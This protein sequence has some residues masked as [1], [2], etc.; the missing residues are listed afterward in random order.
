MN[1]ADIMT[2]PV[3]SVGPDASISAVIRLMVDKRLSGIPVV[4]AD[5]HVLGVLTEGDLLRRAETGTAKEKGKW[6]ELFLGPGRS[7]SDYVHT[8]SRRVSDLMSLEPI[9]VAETTPLSEAIGLME[10]KRIKRL[11]V[12]RHG[13][14]V[15]ILSR[16]D[17][18]R[19]LGERLAAATKDSDTSD[20]G[21]E[22]ALRAALA[23]EPWF[24]SNSITITV[25]DSVVTF[26][27]VIYDDRSRTALRVAAQNTPGVKS[28][29]NN[30]VWVDPTT[31]TVINERVV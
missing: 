5:L 15:G 3:F 14:L 8:H 24:I 21:I 27:G 30:V 25:T 29:V 10:S 23:K 9:S 18:V 17:L 13:A 1:V 12:L 26:D 28:V 20:L 11:P 2:T 6:W 31:A 22:T 19:A 4:D 7:A 16:S